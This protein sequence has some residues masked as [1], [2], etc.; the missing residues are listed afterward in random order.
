MS[1]HGC[2]VLSNKNTVEV[3]GLDTLSNSSQWEGVSKLLTV[4][5]RYTC[6]ICL[7]K[8]KSKR[9][10]FI[11]ACL[12]SSVSYLKPLVYV[13]IPCVKCAQVYLYLHAHMLER[14]FVYICMRMYLYLSF[15][16]CVFVCVCHI[17]LAVSVS[18]GQPHI[19]DMT[20]DWQMVRQ[21][22][23]W[24]PQRTLHQAVNRS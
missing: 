6:C 23:S 18:D 3:K 19:Q 13:C 16:L 5:S 24:Q 10:I 22:S 20:A 8:D 15:S 11:T 4:T 1:L 12:Y 7:K 17:L 14:W 21:H 2:L 9:L